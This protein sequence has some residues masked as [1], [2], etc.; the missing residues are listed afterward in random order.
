MKKY[1]PHLLKPRSSGAF[2]RQRFD[3]TGIKEA[4][5]R[6]GDEL[7]GAV[8]KEILDTI[9]YLGVQPEMLLCDLC[10]EFQVPAH[11]ISAATEAIARFIRGSGRGG[12]SE[13]LRQA[14]HTISTVLFLP[15][16]KCKVDFVASIVINKQ[17]Q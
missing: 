8:R 12:V 6:R 17:Q 4:P 5:L 11:R 14:K 9:K 3:A 7:Y 16:S 2:L 1:A 15:E 13:K 10:E